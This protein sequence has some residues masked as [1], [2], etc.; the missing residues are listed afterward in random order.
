M[1]KD[2]L[3]W[4]FSKLPKAA[5]VVFHIVIGFW[6]Y[7]VMGAFYGAQD[8]IDDWWYELEEIRKMNSEN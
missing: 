4:P 8:A 7:A 2:D 1:N 6:M 5:V 3:R